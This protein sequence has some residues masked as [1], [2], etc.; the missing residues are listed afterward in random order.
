MTTTPT[1]QA[2]HETLHDWCQQQSPAQ[3]WWRQYRVTASTIIYQ[4]QHVSFLCCW[5][6]L[7]FD[8]YASLIIVITVAIVVLV[9]LVQLLL[10]FLLLK[11]A[12]GGGT[13][14]ASVNDVDNGLVSLGADSGIDDVLTT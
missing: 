3:R 11:S 5:Q 14:G 12:G 1:T 10:L 13:R 6:S 9:L 7:R 2:A 4:K 8:V